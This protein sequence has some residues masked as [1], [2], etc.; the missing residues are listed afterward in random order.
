MTDHESVYACARAALKA[1]ARGV[2][3]SREYDEM[4]TCNLEAVGRAVMDA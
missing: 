2:V 1:G 4:R 3:V